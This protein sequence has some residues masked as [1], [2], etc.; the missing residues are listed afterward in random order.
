MGWCFGKCFEKIVAEKI[1]HSIFQTG[2]SVP[3]H[4]TEL[5]LLKGSFVYFFF[6]HWPDP[7]RWSPYVSRASWCTGNACSVSALSHMQLTKPSANLATAGSVCCHHLCCILFSQWVIFPLQLEKDLNWG[8]KKVFSMFCV[9]NCVY[10]Q[11]FQLLNIN[12]GLLG[13]EMTSQR[14]SWGD[15]RVTRG[16]KAVSLDR[17]IE[18]LLINSFRHHLEL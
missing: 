11:D 18:M 4:S 5:G 10:I 7:G 6:L 2:S 17:E 12:E 9:G 1:K 13:A 3:W 16:T 15:T 8:Q 14:H